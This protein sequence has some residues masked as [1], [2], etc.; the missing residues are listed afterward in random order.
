MLEYRHEANNKCNKASFALQKL[1]NKYY[2][3]IIRCANTVILTKR[4]PVF[5]GGLEIFPTDATQE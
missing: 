5:P 2:I 4:K 3:K 1:G